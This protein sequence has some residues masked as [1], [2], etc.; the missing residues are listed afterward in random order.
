MADPKPSLEDKIERWLTVVAFLMALGVVIFVGVPAVFHLL[1][2][3]K[4]ISEV[5]AP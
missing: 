1:H 3:E 4:N 2:H 5:S